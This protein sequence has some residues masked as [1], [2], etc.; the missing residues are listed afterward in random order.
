MLSRIRSG[1]DFRQDELPGVLRAVLEDR[2]L[3]IQSPDPSKHTK[4]ELLSHYAHESFRQDPTDVPWPVLQSAQRFD[5]SDQLPGLEWQAAEETG[6]AQASLER[7]SC[8]TCRR[9]NI[10]SKSR[11][12]AAFPFDRGQPA[13]IDNSG[14]LIARVLATKPK[15]RSGYTPDRALFTQ[16]N[17]S[18]QRTR[19]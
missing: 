18:K 10:S 11:I 7:P 4:G 19:R 5:P 6:G 8:R 15:A 2:F 13:A 17:K 14:P 1:R 12:A 9:R 3:R 16:L